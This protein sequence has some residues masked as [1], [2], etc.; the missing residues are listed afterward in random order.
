M[1]IQINLLSATI[2]P[3]QLGHFVKPFGIKVTDLAQVRSSTN[4]PE[5]G[6]HVI[7]VQPIAARQSLAHLVHALNARLTDEERML[8]FFSSQGDTTLFAS[9]NTCAVYHSEL[10]EPG[11]TKAY[12]LDL[13]DRGECKVMACT[14]AFAQG[15]DR[16]NVR[17]VVIFRPAYGLTVNNQMMGRAGRDGR[18]S[19]VFFVTDAEGITSFRGVKVAQK[20]CIDQLQDV[21]HGEECRRYTTMLCMDGEDLAARCT[22]NSDWIPCDVCVPN[23]PMQQFAIQAINTPFAPLHPFG[24]PSN[25]GA[26]VMQTAPPV[27][28]SASASHQTVRVDTIQD[29]S[30]GIHDASQDPIP[31]PPTSQDSDELYDNS[32]SQITRSQALVLDA[33][34]VLHQPVSRSHPRKSAYADCLSLI[35]TLKA[36]E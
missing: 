18:E 2:P 4:R 22:E 5:I 31:A 1:R 20:H 25:E 32:N 7:H 34:E 36:R 21:V 10:F 29:I 12:N 11:N 8:V 24:G 17:Y 35:A 6:I 30:I 28:A 16:S 23:S 9:Q 27:F 26:N 15:M 13:W 19:H 14:T 3:H 33:M